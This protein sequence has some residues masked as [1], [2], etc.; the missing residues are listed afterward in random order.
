M[1]TT[2]ASDARSNNIPHNFDPSCARMSFGH[3]RMISTWGAICR[4]ASYTATAVT[5]ARLA[6]KGSVSRKRTMELAKRLP[7]GLSQT[8]PSRPRPPSCASARS[9]S[10]SGAPCAARIKRSAFVDPVSATSSKMG[11]RTTPSQHKLSKGQA[12]VSRNSPKVSSQRPIGHLSRREPYHRFQ[13]SHPQH[14][15]NT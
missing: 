15:Q 3:F 5:K 4:T 9:H 1:P 10:P 14:H 6:G 2:T 13:Q 7:F 11:V 12:Q 8:R